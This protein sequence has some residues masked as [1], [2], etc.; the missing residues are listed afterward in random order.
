MST[1]ALP[2]FVRESVGPREALQLGGYLLIALAGLRQE[3][4]LRRSARS[5]AAI[6]ARHNMARELHDGLAQDLAFIA[7]HGTR[8]GAGRAEDHP[9]ESAA[10]R[11]LEV[12]RNA[13]SE[14]SSAS[15]A[16]ENAR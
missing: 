1:M 12:S 11:A 7:A 6:E 15:E 2:G 3:T 5:R 9:L 4:A 8:L 16:N 13:I 14:L 10:R